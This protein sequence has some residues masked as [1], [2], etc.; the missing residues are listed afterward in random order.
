MGAE[1]GVDVGF[2]AAGALGAVAVEEEGRDG[3]GVG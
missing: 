2:L 1:E 3:E